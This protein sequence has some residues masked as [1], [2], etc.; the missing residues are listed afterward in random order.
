MSARTPCS[1]CQHLPDAA[2]GAG[3]LHLWVHLGH[4]YAKLLRF[5]E[6]RRAA[7]EASPDTAHL[8]IEV[9]EGQ[10]DALAIGLAGA[11]TQEELRGIKALFV[12]AGR[13]PGLADYGRVTSL[14][15]FV[16]RSQA[17]WLID[18][19]AESRLTSHYQPIVEARDPQVAFAFE[20]LLRGQEADGS[21]VSPGRMLS[22]ARDADL[23]F[24][25]DLAARRTAITQAAAHGLALPLFIN[26]SPAAIYD[27]AYCLR[28][29]VSSVERSGLAPEQIVFEV[30][31]ADQPFD[32]YHLKGILAFYRH[33]G[34]RVAPDDLGAGF[35]S[36][37]LIHELRPDFIKLD[38]DLVHDVA[39]EP[40]KAQIARAILSM[41]QDLGVRSVAEG[42]EAQADFEWLRGHG[43]DLVQGY[44]F[45]RPGARPEWPPTAAEA[46]RV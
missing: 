42:V 33:A 39:R 19:L 4:S 6:D 34:F 29:T 17:Q 12:E 2:L 18:L 38:R 14:G 10:A 20:A 11:L 36:L 44:L 8:R 16:G 23:L 3:R 45:A 21:L 31:E 24:Q 41:C 37:N 30:I 28:S 5:L 9:G 43:A 46:P 27:P 7:F 40:F 1:R 32:L 15:Q 26:F 35:S 25:L 22:V 13:E